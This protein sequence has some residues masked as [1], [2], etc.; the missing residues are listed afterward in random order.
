MQPMPGQ[1]NLGVSL[2]RFHGHC[3][4][5]FDSHQQDYASDTYLQP[6][7]SKVTLRT[8]TGEI[9]QLLAR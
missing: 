2:A 7:N 8:K 5:H 9:G 1:Q 3:R 4:R 6:D